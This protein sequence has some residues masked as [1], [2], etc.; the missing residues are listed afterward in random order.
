MVAILN[1][2][3]LADSLLAYYA[4]EGSVLDSFD[5]HNGTAEK[6]ISTNNSGALRKA[7]NLDGAS[8]AAQ[9]IGVYQCL[10]FADLLAGF[11]SFSISFWHKPANAGYAVCPLS[12]G[13]WTGSV[14]HP[15]T[16]LLLEHATGASG[17]VSL[18]Y[19]GTVG[20]IALGSTF[21]AGSWHHWVITVGYSVP[22]GLTTVCLYKN[23][24][25]AQSSTVN[26][27][28]AKTSTLALLVG[29]KHYGVS[30][31]F[32]RI[33][34]ANA[35]IDEIA[36]AGRAWTSAEAFDLWH[37]GM[38]LRLAEVVVSGAG[39]IEDY[40]DSAQYAPGYVYYPVTD[41]V[42]EPGASQGRIAL[43]WENPIREDFQRVMLRRSDTSYP[44][45]PDE[46]DLVYEGIAEGLVD[47]GL[48]WHK[49]Y[50][51]S[52]WA[53]DIYG[54][55]SSATKRSAVP[56]PDITPPGPIDDFCAIPGVN[57]IFLTWTNPTDGDLAGI[58]IR[59]SQAGFPPDPESGDL[60]YDG[61]EEDTIDEN[62]YSTDPYYYSGWAYDPDF[63]YSPSTMV[64]GQILIPLEVQTKPTGLLE[65]VTGA[66]G[67]SDS[68]I[69]GF[70][71]T[72]TT[73]MV[74]K[75]SA[76]LPVETTLNWPE[77]GALAIDGIKYRYTSKSL[78]SFL[79]LTCFT[80][81]V[82]ENG[83]L[84]SHRAQSIVM[85]ASREWNAIEQLRRALLVDYAKAE[86]LNVIGR[87]LGVPRIP[88]YSTEEQFRAVI[89]ATAYNPK[90]TML[91]IRLALDA[92]LGPE[93]YSLYEDLVSHPCT[94]Y[95]RI[96][97][98]ES[99][100]LSVGK[101]YFT[102][103][104]WTAIQGIM[105]TLEL[106]DAPL[107]VEGVRLKKMSEVFNLKTAIPSAVTYDYYPEAPAPG[108]A[109]SY[110]GG[111]SE[112]T[113]VLLTA[114][115]YTT[116]QALSIGTVF[117]RMADTQGA[118]ITPQSRAE[119]S[120]LVCIPTGATLKAGELSQASLSLYNGSRSLNI[121]ME[122]DRTIGLY[123]N[124]VGGFLGAT[125]GP[126]ELDRF[127][128]VALK[129]TPR[130][131]AELWVDG[132][133]VSSVGTNL[134]DATSFHRIEFGIRGA[135]SAGMRL[136]VKQVGV[137]SETILDFWN[138]RF[139]GMVE[140]VNPEKITAETAVFVTSDVGKQIEL[141]GA[142]AVN[143]SGG[144]NNGIFCI[145]GLLG[146]AP[147]DT[148]TVQGYPRKGAQV[149]GA[150]PLQVRDTWESM[151][152]CY[153]DDLGKRLVISGSIHGND[154]IYLVTKILLPDT[155]DEITGS[156]KAWSNLCEV[157]GA[158]F[159]GE[160]DLEYR[161]D[162]AFI[163]EA[164]LLLELSDAG[165]QA[166]DVLT[167]RSPL[168]NNGIIM[169]IEYSVMPTAQLM[170][171]EERLN[172]ALTETPPI[173]YRVYPFY[174]A[175]PE[176]VVRAYLDNLTAAGVIAEVAILET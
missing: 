114:G 99:M 141:S 77:S 150:E 160:E 151:A 143:P 18:N 153:P 28:L 21:A 103:L 19:F 163:D 6:T 22:T 26:I 146:V 91:G 20:S 61:L 110:Q 44:M 170:P 35:V 94:L 11:A 14:N 47:L 63:N 41:F 13:G 152:F 147:T 169:E 42:A 136:R 109:F 139:T 1:H 40:M 93:N 55:I 138:C 33:N 57:R 53:Y 27:G 176:G 108:N 131:Q 129:Q 132:R 16:R 105:T 113:N 140:S 156:S 58:L 46:G 92:L 71:L 142:I 80:G 81:G 134:F 162:P 149:S 95:V 49:T 32:Q 30:E 128:E 5:S 54:S 39:D 175:D 135:P 133:K 37:S 106:E 137:F 155:G 168:W 130:G 154:G 56:F 60:V 79:G 164:A 173:T 90:A 4:L 111:L 45:E 117:Y 74:S 97:G 144:T 148:I 62:L 36:I 115:E 172:T 104:A 2:P 119:V 29:A 118:R 38:P 15:E 161:L 70:Q 65:A 82:E 85:D 84:I 12:I 101:T 34:L 76:F 24:F 68:E 59:R 50:Y 10:N 174:L 3:T 88:L 126:L 89:K 123:A 72:R 69:A 124:N 7:I 121:G 127:Y 64:A 78:S 67:E 100:L 51:Y 75:G 120:W 83:T 96:A 8:A 102:S 9:N 66:I 107:K 52:L 98:M 122:S 17:A 167:L 112:G 23:G 48:D 145:S 87:N 116:I 73:A 43:S 31:P 166:G 159:S 25:L 165:I 158:D 125:F 171:I 157:S 86:D